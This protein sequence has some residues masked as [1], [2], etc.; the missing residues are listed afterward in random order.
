MFLTVNGPLGF[1]GA[2]PAF[3][4]TGGRLMEGRIPDSENKGKE[5]M[6]RQ[7]PSMSHDDGLQNGRTEMENAKQAR[8]NTCGPFSLRVNQTMGTMEL[9]QT[10]EKP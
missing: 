6:D 4:R 9:L 3:N 7:R 8:K 2:L 10:G 1:R 5:F